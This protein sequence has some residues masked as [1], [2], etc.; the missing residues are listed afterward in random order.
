MV[1]KE[2]ERSDS[3]PLILSSEAKGLEISA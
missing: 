1:L 2:S 3:T